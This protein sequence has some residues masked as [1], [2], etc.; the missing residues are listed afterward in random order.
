MSQLVDSKSPIVVAMASDEGFRTGLFVT[1]SSLLRLHPHRAV[2]I[3]VIDG[4]LSQDTLSH[5][6]KLVGRYGEAT[7]RLHKIDLLRFSSFPVGPNGSFLTYARLLLGSLIPDRSRIVYLDVDTLVC[8]PIDELFDFPISTSGRRT[9]IYA[10]RDQ[11]LRTLQQDCPRTLPLEDRDLRYVNAGVLLMDLER[12]R[13]FDYEFQC[14]ELLRAEGENCPFWDQTAINFFCRNDV[15]ILPLHWNHPMWEHEH[16]DRSPWDPSDINTIPSI[17]HFYDFEKPWSSWSFHLPYKLWRKEARRCGLSSM[18]LMLQTPRMRGQYLTETL[19]L[20]SR[21]I[22]GVSR[23]IRTLLL[24]R[25]RI[26]DDPVRVRTTRRLIA[27]L[28]GRAPLDVD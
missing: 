12:W 4:G 28:S 15:T 21:S 9:T 27:R 16:A 13:E 7:L 6:Q 2:E 14:L 17:F 25:I 24:S 23:I 3:H 10:A 18:K 19:V 8:K 11:T 1:T 26:E 20:T 22:P 5:L